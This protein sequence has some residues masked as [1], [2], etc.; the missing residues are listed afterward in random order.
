MTGVLRPLPPESHPQLG[1]RPVPAARVASPGTRAG[2]CRL[3]AGCR[4]KAFPP[5]GREA[6]PGL[7]L[8]RPNLP[9]KRLF[10]PIFFLYFLQHSPPEDLLQYFKKQKLPFCHT[11]SHICPKPDLSC[12][13]KSVL[14]YNFPISGDVL[15]PSR[16]RG[17]KHTFF[18]ACIKLL[19]LIVGRDFGYMIYFPIPSL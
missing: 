15:D 18:Q 16:H 11:K 2:L 9:P 6:V 8:F 14:P 12:F 19:T 1:R 13:S 4:P 3:T 7:V 5:P 10:S 17:V